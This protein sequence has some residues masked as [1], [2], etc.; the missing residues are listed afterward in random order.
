MT[1]ARSYLLLPLLAVAA[2]QTQRKP[3]TGFTAQPPGTLLLNNGNLGTGTVELWTIFDLPPMPEQVFLPQLNGQD[4]VVVTS[5]EGFYDYVQLS[6]E[7]WTGGFPY[8]LNGI[9]PGTYTMGIVDSDGESWGQA[10]PLTISAP[11][12][13]LDPFSQQP[14]VIF[15][16]FGGQMGSWTMDPRTKDAD[17]TTDQITV[18]NL[19]DGEVAVERCLITGGSPTSCTPVG[20]VAPGADFSTV[21]TLAAVPATADHQALVISLASDAS[22]SYQRDLLQGSSSFFFGESCQIERILVHGSVSVSSQIP[23][24]TEFA[25]SSCYGYQSGGT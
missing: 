5:D 10:A 24:G 8:S 25:I 17:P 21:E 19:V 9:P 23:L 1:R 14:A 7:G 13:P 20:T 2:C 15:T 18:T 11:V 3:L 22:Q 12:T 6:L 4:A 16:H